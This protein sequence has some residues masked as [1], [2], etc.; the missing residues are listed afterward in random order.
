MRL[1]LRAPRSLNQV[2]RNRCVFNRGYG[3]GLAIVGLSGLACTHSPEP[4][5]ARYSDIKSGA[6]RD[7]Q[8]QSAL[9]LEFQPGDRLPIN[10]DFFVE[11]FELD[12]RRPRL[13]LVA[14]Q[15]CFVRFGPD[16]IRVS[17]DPEHFHSKPRAPGALR[18]GFN[19][20][21]GQPPTL[22]VAI[23]SPRR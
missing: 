5:P 20:T 9:V 10:L 8:G 13:E 3:L 19:S 17:L 12:P 7:Y 21:A 22:D 4:V 6:L 23:T 16:G 11:D 1:P 2:F 18:V 14:K 15:H